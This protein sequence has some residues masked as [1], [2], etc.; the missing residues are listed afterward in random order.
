M[1][2][3]GSDYPPSVP[4]RAD[5]TS[6]NRLKLVEAR[7]LALKRRPEILAIVDA[8]ATEEHAAIAIQRLLDLTDESQAHA[9][10][11]MRIGNWT[12]QFRQALEAERYQLT[13]PS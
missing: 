13:T 4:D 11:Q 1:T 7:L 8:A 12:P 10:L 5:V 6:G 2:D 3:E 9:I